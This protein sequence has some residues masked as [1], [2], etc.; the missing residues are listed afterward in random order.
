MPI[1]PYADVTGVSALTD[2]ILLGLLPVKKHDIFLDK[3]PMSHA[4]LRHFLGPVAN[5]MK[6]QFKY[7]INQSKVT[8]DSGAQPQYFRGYWFRP[9]LVNTPDVVYINLAAFGDWTC[10]PASSKARTLPFSRKFSGANGQRTMFEKG[11]EASLCSH[12][13]KTPGETGDGTWEITL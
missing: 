4:K 11:S 3:C 5:A 8:I 12:V 6:I 2:A 13:K 7:T 10:G 1:I 9:V